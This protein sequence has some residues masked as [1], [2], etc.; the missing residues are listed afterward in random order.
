MKQ[1]PITVQFTMQELSAL[2]EA[3]DKPGS[4]IYKQGPVGWVFNRLCVA[5]ETRVRELQEA[6]ENVAS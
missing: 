4:A 1:K 2:I 5:R 6:K 3:L